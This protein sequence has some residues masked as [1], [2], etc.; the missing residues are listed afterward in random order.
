MNSKGGVQSKKRCESHES[1]VC[2]VG[3]SAHGCQKKSR[4][5][6]MECRHVA[7]QRDKQDQ[8]CSIDTHT[9]IFILNYESVLKW[10]ASAVS[11]GEVLGGGDGVPR[12]QVLQQSSEFSVEVG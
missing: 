2:M 10:K 4:V 9:S 3:F 6:E 8:H 12:E 1:C 7:V 11:P 5:S